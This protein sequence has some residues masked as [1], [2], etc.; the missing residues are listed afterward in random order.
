MC[1]SLIGIYIAFTLASLESV[2]DVNYSTALCT[3]FGV[4]LQ[5]FLLV[6]FCW[7]MAESVYLYIK[8]VIVMGRSISHF[9][10]KAGLLAWSE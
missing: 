1:L 9:T 6:Y 7:T 5:Y 10:L 2:S 8:L 3:T 4:L